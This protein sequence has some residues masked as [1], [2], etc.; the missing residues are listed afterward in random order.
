MDE[1]TAARDRAKFLSS[2]SD[3]VARV[4]AKLTKM[5]A[6]ENEEDATHRRNVEEE[7]QRVREELERLGDDVDWWDHDPIVVIGA[8]LEGKALEAVEREAKKAKREA[9]EKKVR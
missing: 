9:E 4:R 8:P 7:G 6:G 2:I 3:D 5:L 1:M